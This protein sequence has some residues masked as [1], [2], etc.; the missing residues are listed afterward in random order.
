MS[1]ATQL[2]PS[3]GHVSHP[4]ARCHLQLSKTVVCFCIV[5]KVLY[6]RYC[7]QGTVYKVL[8]TRYCVQGTVHKVLCTRYCTQG[9]VYKVLYT[10]YCVQG[11]VHKVLYTR[12]CTQGLPSQHP[13]LVCF[14]GVSTQSRHLDHFIL[15]CSP[16]S[17][18]EIQVCL[19]K[20]VQFV[21]L[22]QL[23]VI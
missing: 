2:L 20:T 12:Y 7:V 6:T 14:S 5:H 21:W 3:L 8:C 13:S 19:V 23:S 9:T 10:R 16:D 11:T 22:V 1:P 4:Q 17:A 18:S 15:C